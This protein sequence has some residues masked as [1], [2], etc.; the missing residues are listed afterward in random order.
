MSHDLVIRGGLIVD[1]TGAP[2][3]R[4]PRRRRRPHRR[5]RRRDGARRAGDRRR[6]PRGGPGFIDPHTHYDAQLTW[7]PLAS[8]S[9]WHGVTTVVTGNC[10]FTIAPCRTGDRETMMR[11]L[12]YVEGMSLD[13]MPRASAGTSRASASTSTRS[14]GAACG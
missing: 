3:A 13:A 7:D 11:M 12:Q 4:R 14:T 1:G 9:S 10:G 2:P 6:R 8:C 5:G